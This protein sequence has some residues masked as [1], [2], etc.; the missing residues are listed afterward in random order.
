MKALSQFNALLEV[1]S[2]YTKGWAYMQ[3]EECSYKGVY[4]HTGTV[5]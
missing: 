3:R 4:L 1:I 2:P 5:C